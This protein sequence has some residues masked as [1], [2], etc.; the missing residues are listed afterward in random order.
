MS[1]ILDGRPKRNGL[2]QQAIEEFVAKRL[3]KP[4]IAKAYAR[5]TTPGIRVAG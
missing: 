2:I 3:E 4:E 5:V 1:Q